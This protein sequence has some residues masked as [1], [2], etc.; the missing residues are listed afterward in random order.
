MQQ[1]SRSQ[2]NRE[3]NHGQMMSVDMIKEAV[4]IVTMQPDWNRTSEALDLVMSQA[5]AAQIYN[6]VPTRLV[7]PRYGDNGEESLF[8]FEEAGLES[9]N[10]PS[11][12]TMDEYDS[13]ENY[14]MD[15][16]SEPTDESAAASCIAAYEAPPPPAATRIESPRSKRQYVILPFV[17]FTGSGPWVLYLDNPVPWVLYRCVDS[18]RLWLWHEETT[19]WFYVD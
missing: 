4:F 13:V 7:V 8:S 2:S 6:R 14:A 9:M 3:L 19:K 5:K 12:F 1:L 10:P 15:N 11:F 18:H 17:G 16:S